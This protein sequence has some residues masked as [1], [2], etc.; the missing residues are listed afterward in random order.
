MHRIPSLALCIT[1]VQ[2]LSAVA[3]AQA[4]PGMVLSHQK[5]SDTEGGFTGIL[6]DLDWFGTSVAALGD[7]DGDG[8]GDLAVGA[9]GND[10]GRPDE[11]DV[12][13]VFSE[14]IISTDA[15][16]ARWVFAADLDGDGDID[17]LSA[18]EFGAHIVWYEN[19]DGLGSFGSPQTI[20]TAASNAQSVFAIDLDGDGDIDVLSASLGNQIAWDENTDG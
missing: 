13:V 14:H 4:Q 8:V 5:I 11:C 15:D 17:V 18:S 2:A 20:T 6:D 9:P 3:P 19:T 16:S 12:A 10:S 1:L 7:L